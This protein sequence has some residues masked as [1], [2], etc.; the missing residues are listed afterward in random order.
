MHVVLGASGNTGHVVAQNLL[1]RQQKVRVVGRNAAHLQAHSAQGAE[2]FIA[3]VTDATALTK[4]F[5][6]ADSAYVMIPP[7]PASNDPLAYSER[8]GDAIAAALKNAGVKNVVMLSSIGADKNKGTGPVI[9][10]YKLEQ[11]LNQLG[12]ANVLVLRAGYFMENTLPQAV[13]VS[14]M[15]SSVG[16]IRPDLK[17][18][19]I[20]TRD[21]GA[22]A[23][24]ALLSLSFRGKQTQELLG[25]RDIAYAEV[26][27][28]IGKA[29]GKPDLQYKQLPDEQMRPALVQM[30]MSEPFARLLLEMTGALNSG[31]MRALEP[32]TSQNSTATTYEDFVAEVFVPAYQHQAA[33]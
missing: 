29:I 19:M 17:L 26:A 3:D 27:A 10:L 20:A 30:G 24:D 21:I 31:Y 9:G 32:R 25:Q 1:A 4:A 14:K 11:K 33:A 15:G 23:S 13:A 7:N 16:P 18:Q 22:F 12:G 2:V 8:A 6:N 28:I 5:H